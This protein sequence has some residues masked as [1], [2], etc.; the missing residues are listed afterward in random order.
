MGSSEEARK[1]I[2]PETRVIDLQG[3]LA[4]PGFIDDHTHFIDSGFHLLSVQ[5][6][7][8]ATPAEFARRIKEHAAR[9]AAGRWITG[10]DWDHELWPGSPLPTKELIDPYTENNPVF[11]SRLDGHMALANSAAL[12]LAKITK[13]TKDPPGGTIVRDPKTGEP[14]G[15]LKDDAMG[16]VYAKIPWASAAELD[17]ALGAALKEAAR[18][19]VTS[20][21]D[22]T[23]WRDY[24]V[25]KKFRDSNR[26]TVRVY[27][28][29][30]MSEW[31]R[32]ADAVARQGRGDDWL[33][34][35]GLKAFMDGSLGSTTA[36]FFEPFTD[37][38]NTSG[39]ML[40]D[41]HTRRQD[42]ADDQGRRPC[43]TA[44]LDSRYRR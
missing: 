5:L 28:R 8:A 40:E 7:T 39:L 32:Q 29:T 33:R 24:E 11:V 9:L 14:T 34:L 37:A 26:L 36:L 41:E 18:V 30:P 31:K 23:P 44:M 22:I 15:V 42:E 12:R 38:P 2:G 17:E 25:Y 6:R 13:E 1:L 19:G 35:G 43:W 4:L 10:G 21:Q 27:A 16:L 20:I 3:K